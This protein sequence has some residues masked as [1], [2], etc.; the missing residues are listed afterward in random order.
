MPVP[1]YIIRSFNGLKNVPAY[2]RRH[3][4]NRDRL[5]AQREEAIR[6][7]K[8]KKEQ[9]FQARRKLRRAPAK[10]W[11]EHSYNGRLTTVHWEQ[12]STSTQ[13]EPTGYWVHEEYK[14]SWTKHGDF[15]LPDVRSATL[16]GNGPAAVEAYYANLSKLGEAF[17]RHAEGPT[18]EPEVVVVEPAP[19]EQV[20][21][22][23][24]AANARNR[25][26]N[27]GAFGQHRNPP[28]AGSISPS[29][30]TVGGKRYRVRGWYTDTRGRFH[31]NLHTEAMERNFKD[32]ELNVDL[33]N[34]V[35]INSA[36]MSDGIE[37][38]INVGTQYAADTDYTI[39]IG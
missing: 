17:I 16:Y 5:D 7:A 1:Q 29:S 14:G 19:Q 38:L 32:A 25:S 18:L 13:L 37:L 33:G 9:E 28:V 31:L 22:T 30:F 39:R 34:G 35:T 36:D 10:V 15:V 21:L 8:E 12:T 4:A 20:T 23:L 26:G 11:L 24:S 27:V 2:I 3:F 6:L